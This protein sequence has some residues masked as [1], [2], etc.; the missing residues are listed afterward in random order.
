VQFSSEKC[1]KFSGRNLI[2]FFEHPTNQ[3]KIFK[4]TQ[5]AIL[6]LCLTQKVSKAHFS[7]S[8]YQP[9]IF[10]IET[11]IRMTLRKENSS[12]KKIVISFYSSLPP[13]INKI[14]KS[15]GY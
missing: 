5:N 9:F 13:Q 15:N 7:L 1:N 12:L 2:A 6:P 10:I 3:K 11:D 4:T 14:M 8:F